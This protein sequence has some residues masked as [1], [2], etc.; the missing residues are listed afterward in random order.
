MLVLVVV[1]LFVQDFR[2]TLIT[3]HNRRFEEPSDCEEAI[4]TFLKLP[5]TLDNAESLSAGDI[6]RELSFRGFRG[7]EYNA[8]SIGKAM[9]RLGFE[10]RKIRGTN[11]YLTAKIDPD[12]RNRENKEDAKEFVPEVF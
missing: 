9:K 11:K 7:R 4:L 2:A 6:M 5:D 12:M 3:D 8:N 1:Y 10:K